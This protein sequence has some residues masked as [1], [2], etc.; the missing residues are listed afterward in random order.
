M[1]PGRWQRRGARKRI[2]GL[3][4]YDR[5]PGTKLGETCIDERH[6]LTPEAMPLAS[7]AAGASVNHGYSSLRVQRRPFGKG[8]DAVARSTAGGMTGAESDRPTQDVEMGP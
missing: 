8:H 3:F 4:G 1:A 2:V 7:V 6:R 5:E